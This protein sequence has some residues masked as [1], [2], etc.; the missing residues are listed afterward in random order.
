MRRRPET[1]AGTGPAAFPEPRRGIATVTAAKSTL[2]TQVTSDAL[3][4][5]RPPW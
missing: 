4:S 1:R 5:L 2:G 3:R